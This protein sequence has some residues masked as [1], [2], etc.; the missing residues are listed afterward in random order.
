MEEYFKKKWPAL[1]KL[2]PLIFTNF[3]N[4]QGVYEEVHD[5]GHLMTKTQEMLDDFNAMA[6]HQMNLVLFLE[7]VAHVSKVVRVFSLPLGNALL[8]GIGGSGRKSVATLAASVVEYDL[9]GI[10]ISKSYGQADWHDDLKRLLL[11][12]GGKQKPNVFLF[13]DTQVQQESFLEDI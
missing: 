9:F 8:V 5:H 10:E 13:S 7:F 1:V 3:T 4:N 6:K 11:T 12:V 2:E